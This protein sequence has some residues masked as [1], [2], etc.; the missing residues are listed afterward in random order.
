L[1]KNELYCGDNLEIMRTLLR[2]RGAFIDLIYID[3]PFGRNRDYIIPFKNR[4]QG[5]NA[6]VA[7]F[8]NAWSNG[9]PQKTI[10]EIQD[11]EVSNLDKCLEI[12][13]SVS[14]PADLP[15]LLMM[16]IR[17][18]YMRELLKDAGGFYLHCDQTT[19]HYLRIVCDQIFGADNF[20]NEIIWHY[21]TGGMSKRH[22]R[23][24][25]DVILFYGKTDK[26]EFDFMSVKTA[27]AEKVLKRTANYKGAR[28]SA[29]DIGR[30]A[31]DVFDIVTHNRAS[32]EQLGYPTQ[33][34]LALLKRII[35]AS[36]AEGDIVADFFCGCGTTIAA[37]I[38]LKR[39]YIGVDVSTHSIALIQKRI[40]D[41][42]N[43]AEKSHYDLHE[44]PAKL[45]GRL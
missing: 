40:K 39:A 2:E 4:E 16:M 9:S 41:A 11:L 34:P 20:V 33:K 21:Q 17:I 26:Y 8:A 37:A 36:S 45:E 1:A 30:I 23:R 22:F 18:Y 28:F 27:R 10:E 15:Y 3:P 32:N 25:H 13:K 19:S 35:M 14:P 24:S 38:E 12:V 44:A 42:H 5:E 7:A 31:S 29:D 43:H 6:Q